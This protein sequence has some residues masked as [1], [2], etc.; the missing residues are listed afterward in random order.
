MTACPSC[1]G[2]GRR[3]YEVRVAA[4]GAWRGGY[5]DERE[6]DCHLCDG[7]GDVDEEVAER[8]DPFD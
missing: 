8:Y 7:S 3:W 6:M 1:G 2:E 5:L 4:P